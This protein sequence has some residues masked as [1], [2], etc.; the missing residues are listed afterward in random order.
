MLIIALAAAPSQLPEYTTTLRGLDEYVHIPESNP[1]TPAKIA[2]GRKLFFDPLLSA[3]RTISC[4]S[5]HQPALAFSDTTP[6]SRAIHG[7]ETTRNA[8][9]ILNRAYG[10]SFF[11]D[12][13]TA[14]LEE[15]VLEPIQNPLE[16]ALPLSS[17][18]DRLRENSDYEVLFAAAFRDS[19]TALNLA[20]S[21]AAYLRT[22]RSGDSP[23]DR[24][25]AGERSALSHDAERGFE[26][27]FGKANC[28][29][30]HSG[31]LLSDE[32]LHITGVST[33]DRGRELF[34]R[35]I[36]DRGA[37]KV[38]SLRN[39][40]LTAPY[41]HD[42]SLTTLE[43]VVDFY[44]RGGGAV[45]GIDAELRPLGLTS[46]EKRSLVAFLRSLTAASYSRA[47]K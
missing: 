28:F 37:F 1:P 4:A 27:F 39:V 31:P 5:C 29:A 6:R 43:S 46:E 30:C 45:M 32:R 18:I 42:G 34:T 10:S 3:D 8:P 12:G 2:L 9:S 23:A 16:M 13:R 22:I 21:L 11:W 26:L 36:E 25:V 24:Y 20:R 19:T 33:A 17:L 7:A 47:S 44:D 40:A 41:M 35:R 38:P 15:A 14:S